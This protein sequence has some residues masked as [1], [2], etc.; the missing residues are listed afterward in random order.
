MIFIK[1]HKDFDFNKFNIQQ[2][3][4][5]EFN[6]IS[7]EQL[8]NNYPIRILYENDGNNKLNQ[9][10]K[11]YGE[12]TYHYFVY[13]HLF[14]FDDV[15]GMI[16]YRRAFSNYVLNNYNDILKEYDAILYKCRLKSTIIQNY[17]SFHKNN[18][19]NNIIDLLYE[20]K[21]EYKKFDF[22]NVTLLIPHNIFIMHKN[23]FIEYSKFIFWCCDLLQEHY[24]I[25]QYNDDKKYYRMLSLLGERLSTIFYIQYFLDSNK[26]IYY[27]NNINL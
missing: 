25:L 11:L 24:N 27:D 16:Q 4:Y 13:K 19:L 10:N 20:Y 9:Y 7:R 21:P 8:N 17:E 26:K 3:K 1:T 14:L 15:I 6:I 23:D 2:N 12:L 18:W 5:N 22:K